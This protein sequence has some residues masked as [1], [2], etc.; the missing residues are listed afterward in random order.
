MKKHKWMSRRE[1]DQLPK[2]KPPSGYVYVIKD[3]DVSGQYKIGKTKHPAARLA[4]FGVKLPFRTEVVL[5]KRSNNA[6]EAEKV[7][8]RRFRCARQQ[9]EWFKL[10]DSQVSSIFAWDA[11]V[12]VPSIPNRKKRKSAGRKTIIKD[13]G[14][15]EEDWT[16]DDSERID[17]ADEY[18]LHGEMSYDEEL[19]AEDHGEFMPEEDIE[20]TVGNQCL[21]G[22]DLSGMNLQDY[23]MRGRDLSL[24]NLWGAELSNTVFVNSDLTGAE[25]CEADMSG[26]DLSNAD[27]QNCNL[28]GANLQEACLENANLRSANLTVATLSK[29]DLTGARFDKFTILPDGNMWSPESD[30]SR[31]T[32]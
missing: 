24:A 10:T 12:V 7:L 20:D 16:D 13:V 21:A 2:L 30:L 28:I 27:L 19:E 31:F 3:I 5:V 26:A 29:A 8:H 9:G 1:V 15:S 6:N 14:W 23:D 4:N 11:N 22:M 18:R 25:L 17:E 32:R